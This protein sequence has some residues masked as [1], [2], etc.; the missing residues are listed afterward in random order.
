[1]W[2]GGR[3]GWAAFAVVHSLNGVGELTLLGGGSFEI[4]WFEAS[5]FDFFLRWRFAVIL[6]VGSGVLPA[7]SKWCGVFWGW[8]R[9]G[10]R[11]VVISVG[12]RFSLE[13]CFTM[14][15]WG[16][17]ARGS[18]WLGV[19]FHCDS[20]KQGVFGVCFCFEWCLFVICG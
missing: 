10:I 4:R 16:M 9:L 7:E 17:G 20:A 11:F 12:V 2:W 18:V 1:M 3:S 5:G 13:W 8:R 19:A 15:G 6:V 14:I